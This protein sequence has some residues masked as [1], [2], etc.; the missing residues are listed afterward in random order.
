MEDPLQG[1]VDRLREE[2]GRVASANCA[3][4]SCLSEVI[5]Q[6][7]QANEVLSSVK[8]DMVELA[9]A[10]SSLSGGIIVFSEAEV[11]VVWEALMFFCEG[12]PGHEGAALLLQVVSDL[13]ED[14]AAS[15]SGNG[16]E[17]GVAGRGTPGC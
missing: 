9:G 15:K 14:L 2:N 17:V 12:A 11:G 16:G 13:M 4:R 6:V 5:V 1:E 7:N 10:A 3:L 8:D